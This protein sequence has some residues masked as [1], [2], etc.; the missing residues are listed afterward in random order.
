M[1]NVG[2]MGAIVSIVICVEAFW[3]FTAVDGGGAVVGGVGF[4]CGV[5]S[6]GLF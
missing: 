4:G 6:L 3:P 5:F 1:A 2:R